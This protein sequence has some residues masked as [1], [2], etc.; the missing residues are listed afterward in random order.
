MG[1]VASFHLIRE[2]L[3]KS[4]IAM[5]RLGSDRP[6]LNRVEGLAFWRLLG[7]GRG[8][9]TGSGA[10]TARTALF[11]VWENEVSLDHFLAAHHIARRWNGAEEHWSV[12]LRGLGGHG[13]WR[14]FDPLSG[15]DE[16]RGDGPIAIVTRARVR[17]RAWREFAAAS[18][19]VD[20]ELH[21]AD[22]LID[23]VGIGEAPLGRLATFSLWESRAA[24]RAFAYAMPDHVDVVRRTRAEDWYTEELF[25]RFEPYVTSGSWDGRD[26]LRSLDAEE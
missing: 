20:R 16:G 2:P 22:G 17:P 3:W 6:R 21:A 14:G 10:D 7:T 23:V 19:R 15:L 4:P 11:A 18:R 12:R 9:N 13:N 26:P 24:A 25:A 1:R 5:A 8:D